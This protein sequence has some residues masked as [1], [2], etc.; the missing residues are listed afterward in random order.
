MPIMVN[1][2]SRDCNR[3]RVKVQHDGLLVASGLNKSTPCSDD[4][5]LLPSVVTNEVLVPNSSIINHG[6]EHV[7]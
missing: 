3:E 6:F 7:P 5:V 4:S 2:L 1:L